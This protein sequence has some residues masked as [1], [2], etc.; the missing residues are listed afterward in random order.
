MNEK[1]IHNFIIYPHGAYPVGN[2]IADAAGNLYGTTNSGG[3]H[4]YGAVFELTRKQ[5]GRWVETVLHSFSRNLD[6]TGDGWGPA[7]GLTFDASGNLFGT[8]GYGGRNDCVDGCGTI[9]EF[10][11]AAGGK[12]NYNIIYRFKGKNDGNYPRPGVVSDVAGNLYGTAADSTNVNGTVFELVP[13]SKG[14]TEKT[15]YEFAA[16]FP[17]NLAIDATGKLYGVAGQSGDIF[18]LVRRRNGKWTE[19]TVCA[20][21]ATGTP[22]FDQA[23][24]LYVESDNQILE[25]VRKQHWAEFL[26][27][28][29]TGRDGDGSTGILTFD[30]SGNLYGT[31]Q[32]GGEVGSCVDGLGCGTA[33][34]LTH[35]KG[36]NWQL[37]VLYRFKGN[38]DGELPDSGVVLDQ[39]GNVYGTTSLGGDPTCLVNETL[40][41][42]GTVYELAPTSDGH[43]KHSV[44]NRPGVGDG[45]GP[46]GLIADGFGS[47]YGAMAQS[48]NGGCGMVYQLTPTAQAGWTE[49][50]LYQFKCGTGDGTM[51]LSS[52]TLDSAGNLYGTTAEGGNLSSCNH[53]GCGT[54]FQ[55]S[56]SSGGAWTETVLY[57]FTGKAD[58]NSPAGGLLFDTAGNLYGTTEYGGG[59]RCQDSNGYPIGCGAVYELSPTPQG[60]WK[61]RSLHTFTDASND[62]AFPSSALILDQAGNLYGT[63]AE[64][65]N[66][67]CEDDAGNLGCGMAF[68]LSPSAGGVWTET[69]IYNFSAG[70]ADPSYSN[71]LT[72]NAQGNLF[73]TTPGGGA[74]TY[75]P[76]GCGTV[77][78]LV[79]SSGGWIATV[80]YNFGGSEAD[81]NLPLGTVAF[82]ES[83]NLYGATNEGGGSL[84]CVNCG[85][86]FQLAPASG[87]GWTESVLHS[88]NGPYGDGQGPLTGVILNAAGNIYGTTHNG[89]VDDGLYT[90]GG[91]VFEISP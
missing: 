13:S 22:A 27:G 19:N 68:E 80:L 25:L 52:L 61:E 8:T 12:W 56:P 78:E 67:P 18:Q 32:F 5:D 72:M 89:G 65:G 17:F 28:G 23:G 57:R 45:T 58:G 15:I 63:T 20:C 33:F 71:G 43:W 7:G 76:Y 21:E 87:G 73:G 69:V 40:V 83:G 31:T 55:L 51:P 11:P 34:K 9:F 29:F 79:P 82:D 4:G 36:F 54:V 3:E 84:S 64:G 30:P 47:L 49:R 86:V 91:T 37:T 1:V 39:A 53:F 88:F 59:G 26:I 41:G 48:P 24:N 85:T 10:T 74:S 62:G 38:R 77:Y 46:S 14:W 50:I 16:E 35:K 6:R 75:C 70:Y 60:K 66:G 44:I 90:N 2:L 81:G 42:C